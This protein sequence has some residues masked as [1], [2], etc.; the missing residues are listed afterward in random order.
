MANGSRKIAPLSQL[1]SLRQG[2]DSRGGPPNVLFHEPPARS[3]FQA[4]SI[5]SSYGHRFLKNITA[6]RRHAGTDRGP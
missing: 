3:E 6:N 5:P 4:A 2:H 1:S